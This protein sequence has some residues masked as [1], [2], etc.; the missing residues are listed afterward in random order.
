MLIG[1][2]GESVAEDNIPPCNFVFLIDV[3][4]SMYSNEKLPLLKKSFALLISKL[5][6]QDYV[7][8]VVYASS[9]GCVLPATSGKEKQTIQKAVEKLEAGGSTAGGEGIK[10]AYSIAEKN[11]I[12]NGNNRIILATDGDFNVGVS[13]D[14]ELERLIEG[15][16]DKGIYLTILGFGMGNYKDSKMEK[17]SNKGNGNYAY[18]DNI[19]EANKIFG[20]E[21][22]GTLYTIA[23]DVKIQIEFNPAKVKEYRLVGYENRLLDKEDFNDDKKDAGEIGSGHSVTALYELVLS[24]GTFNKGKVDDLNYQTGNIVPSEDLMTLKVRYKKPGEET[25]KLITDRIT[26]KDIENRGKFRKFHISIFGCGIW[27]VVAG[28]GIQRQIRL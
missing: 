27:H 7:S 20:H 8:I 12:E 11:F 2:Q 28:F 19:L 22:W 3:S 6:P 17:L 9:T 24:D 21:L 18:I 25:S 15:Y 14:S 4:G 5:R 1:I 23:K 26:I 16:R 10:L 13:S